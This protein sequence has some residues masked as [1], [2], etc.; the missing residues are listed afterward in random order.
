[1]KRSSS[2]TAQVAFDLLFGLQ[3]LR[4]RSVLP[5]KMLA[6]GGHK[7]VRPFATK[8]G[9]NRTVVRSVYGRSLLMPAEHP[10][11]DTV[12]DYPQYNRPLALSVLAIARC[13]PGKS[14]TVI[15]I[16][17]NIGDTAAVIEERLPDVCDYLCIE[18]G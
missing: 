1:M 3:S 8:L 18:T 4:K 13:A 9:K 6:K 12:V 10:L 15:D 14:L 16:G 2:A 5:V 7:L 17:A 11:P